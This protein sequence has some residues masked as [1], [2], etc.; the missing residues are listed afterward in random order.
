M[1]DQFKASLL[2][3][4]IHF[5]LADPKLLSSSVLYCTHYLSDCG[6]SGGEFKDAT[7]PRW[8]YCAN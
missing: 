3:K 4:M 8:L 5:F 7:F 6:Y 1:F 2:N